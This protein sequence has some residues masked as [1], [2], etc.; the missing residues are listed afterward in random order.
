MVASR[1]AV[2]IP[3]LVVGLWG[4]NYFTDSFVINGFSGDPFPTIVDTSSGAVIVGLQE[5]NRGVH[6]A[7]IDLLSPISAIDRGPATQPFVDVT[8]LTLLGARTRGGSMDLPRARFTD[9]QVVSLHPCSEATCTVGT[10][11]APR[12]FDAILGADGF[13]GDALRLRLA[14]DP[15]TAEDHIFVLPDIAG[16]TAHRSHACDSVFPNPFR[17][18]GTLVIG[19]TELAF[20]N[21]RIALDV[22]IA[23]DPDP[24]KPQRDRG[25]DTLLVA[26]TAIGITLL[27]RTA[28]DRYHQMNIASPAFSD[29]AE[30]ETVLLPSGPITGR[31]TVLPKIALVAHSGSSPRAPCREVY[32]HHLLLDQNCTAEVDCPCSDGDTFCSVPA[33]IELVPPSGI[34]VLVVDDDDPT[35]QALRAELHPD[36]PEIDGILGTNALRQLEL[37]IDYPNRRILGRCTSERDHCSARPEIVEK[38]DRAQVS[39]CIGQ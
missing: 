18:G 27:N 8:T 9:L 6:T 16:D 11:S 24:S 32:A 26:S 36:Q 4:C 3:A 28:Y 39:G 31:K 30:V 38:S 21:W 12:E 5:P 15:A 33:V 35:L 29:L 37:D 19:G 34:A 14:S 7:V 22:C 17:G 25:T 23:P 20:A 2:G 10:P 13:A 1:V